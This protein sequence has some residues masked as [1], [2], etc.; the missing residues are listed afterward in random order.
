MIKIKNVTFIKKQEPF[1][2]LITKFRDKS[3]CGEELK[4]IYKNLG[5][6]FALE[7]ASCIKFEEFN[8]VTPLNKEYTGTRC[9]DNNLL[10]VSTFED[11]EIFAKTIGD[12]YEVQKYAMLNVDRAENG[13]EA[14]VV[15][16]ELPKNIGDVKTIVFCKSVLAT[17]CT[18]KSILKKISELCNPESIIVIS[19]ISSNEA[20]KELRDKYRY[21]NINFLVGEID[22]LDAKSGVLL[23]GLGMIENRLKSVS[24]I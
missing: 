20:I 7:L 14:S 2:S 23:P 3:Y 15:S 17:G 1:Q 24:N 4:K 13:W 21:L 11:N 16:A 22:T 9:V 12:F 10:F 5:S 19:I 8:I 6:I 18:A